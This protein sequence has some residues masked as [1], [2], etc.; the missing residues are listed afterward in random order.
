VNVTDIKGLVTFNI[1]VFQVV[2]DHF[3]FFTGRYWL[4]CRFGLLPEWVSEQIK[5]AKSKDL[6]AWCEAVLTAPTLEAVF[7]KSDV[8]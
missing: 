8:S 6:E 4:E 3:N 2:S 1:A 5:C 7:N